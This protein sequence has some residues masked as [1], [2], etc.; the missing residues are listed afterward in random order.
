MGEF[1]SKD[2]LTINQ[3]VDILGVESKFTDT[4]FI[5]V[6]DGVSIKNIKISNPNTSLKDRL[7]GIQVNGVNDVII[8]DC[9]ISINDPYSAY[10]IY[11]LEASNCTI[12]NNVL[13]ARGNYFTVALLSF[14]SRD[15]F[16]DG[17]TLRTIGS[18]ET[19]L[20]NNKSCL[21]GYL[22]VC[23]DACLDGSVVCPDGYVVC[24]DG[25]LMCPDGDIIAPEE[26]YICVDGSIVCV[27]GTVICTDG[28]TLNGEVCTD[29]VCV[30][31][32]TYCID[33][34]IILENG[35][36]LYAGGYQI[37]PENTIICPDGAIINPGE[38][39]VNETDGSIICTDGT[40]ICT[41]GSIICTDGS[42]ICT[43]GTGSN[44][45]L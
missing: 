38:Y 39:T 2:K 3:K 29:G 43:D 5:I 16:I 35:T 22:N 37:T 18:G 20:I 14:N 17:N 23:I 32:V 19:Y 44:N 45:Y 21:D 6:N 12:I 13:E 36:K 10:A 27:D 11:L 31:G 1:S 25:S 26:Y 42:T 30:D 34:T 24:P 7:W 28:T 9:D 33:G 4:T 8:Q 40:V 41:D 15:I